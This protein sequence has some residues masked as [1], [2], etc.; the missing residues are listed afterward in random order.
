ML[1]LACLGLVA[2][3]APAVMAR[4]P[5]PRDSENASAQFEALPLDRSAQ[6][7]LIVR[8]FINKKPALLAVDTG[9]P[10]SAIA[11]NRQKHFG[12]MPVAG[13]SRVMI[14][15]AFSAVTIAKSLRI[16]AL[17]LVD[18][19][20]VALDLG[21]GSRAAR[22]RG[23]K[24]IDGLLGADILFPLRAV[25]DCQRQLLILNL[26]PD[27]PK[28]TPGLDF[29]GLTSVPIHVSDGANLY[30]DGEVNGAPGQLLVD[31]GAFATLLHRSFVR[32][33]KI[34][35]RR[36]RYISAGVNTRETD[37]QVAR[38]RRLSVGAVEILGHRVGVIDLAGLLGD[39]ML[40]GK[41][42]VVGLLGGELLQSLHGIIDFGTRRLYLKD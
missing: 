24:N 38:I 29:T 26:D 10:V 39:E 6:N 2:F 42:P 27:S 36:T 34:P 9:A 19:P 4:V 13:P 40:E 20:L 3:V 12:L 37:V 25:L 1:A 14:N 5:A 22:V 8:A 23:E 33:M 7:H 17:T 30:V 16:G 15:G 18:E 11:L 32:Q 41:R 31:T 21:A 28:A 35:L